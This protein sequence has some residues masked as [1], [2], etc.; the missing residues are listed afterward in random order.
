MRRDRSLQANA[1][2]YKR[3]WNIAGFAP[4]IK[5][6]YSRTFSTI[7]L[8]DQNACAPSSVSPRLSETNRSFWACLRRAGTSVM[9]W[10]TDRRL[11]GENWKKRTSNLSQVQFQSRPRW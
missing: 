4:S 8:Y 9:G 7:A 6:S 2:I 1:S 5:L 11:L 3:D 10:E